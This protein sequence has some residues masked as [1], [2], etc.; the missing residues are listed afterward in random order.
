MNPDIQQT[1]HINYNTII[2]NKVICDKPTFFN[3][4]LYFLNNLN[5]YLQQQSHQK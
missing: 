5:F 2:S 4:C 1:G 3:I